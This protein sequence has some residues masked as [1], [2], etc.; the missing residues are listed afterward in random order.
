MPRRM[1]S[2]A[3][4]SA[5]IEV[6]SPFWVR[7]AVWALL[8]G[9][10]TGVAAATISGATSSTASPRG[11][12]VLS[13]RAA[14]TANAP[15]APIARATTSNVAPKMS[16]SDDEMLSTSPVGMRRLSTCPSCTDLRVTSF[17]VPYSEIS[18]PR[19]A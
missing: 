8:S 11:P 17:W 6:S 9:R 5:A 3:T 12:D 15:S 7:S 10:S 4:M 16:E 2:P 14:T 19:T 13:I 1:R 18:Q